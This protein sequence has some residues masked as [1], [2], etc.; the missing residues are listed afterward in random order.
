MRLV[1]AGLTAMLAWGSFG[2]AVPAVQTVFVIVMENHNWSEIKG[3]TNAPYVNGTLL[4]MASSCAQ[5]YNPPGLHPSEPNY[6]WMEA[7]TNFGILNDLNPSVNH[8]SSTNHLV[9]LLQ[10]AGVSWRAYQEDISG[11]CVPLTAT[12]GYAPKHNPFVFFDDVTGTNNPNC[13]YG[14]A[15]IRPYSELAYDLTN[16][17]VAQYNFI[18]PTLC[19]DM[20]DT[21]APL[22]NAIRQGDTWLAHEAPKIL[23]SP[24]YQNSGALFIT[25]DEGEGSDGPI[26]MLLLS[27]L[28]K[29]G[30][31]CSTNRYTHSS[32]LRTIQEIFGVAPLLGDAANA[33]SLVDL[34]RCTGLNAMEKL[35]DGC[36]RLAATG[37]VPGT[38][39]VVEA[40]SD[41]VHWT[42]VGT[43]FTS[44][45]SF[46]FVDFSSTNLAARFYRVVQRP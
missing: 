32:L 43:N 45:G 46:T 38:T 5:Y 21:C 42:A 40:S 31:Y 6:L 3:S 26:G 18:T 11:A 19:H 10:N 39:N 23:A 17:T 12:N 22:G 36:F 16:G 7:G 35:S 2:A 1:L 37:L 25:W 41:F 27:P 9:T 28:A 29:G 13:A 14:I 24:A 44:G 8:Q 33:T 30:G 4:S 15:H 20:H 34:F